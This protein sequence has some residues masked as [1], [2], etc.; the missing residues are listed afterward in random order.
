MDQGPLLPQGKGCASGTPKA[1]N[2]REQTQIWQNNQ[3]RN[4]KLSGTTRWDKNNNHRT[5][6]EKQRH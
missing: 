5:M 2:K 3:D 4:I 6:D 1:K